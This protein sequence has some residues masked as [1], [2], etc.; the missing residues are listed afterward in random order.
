MEQN[1]LLEILAPE[2]GD[3]VFTESLASTLQAVRGR[4]RRRSAV[5]AAGG[6]VMAVTAL[7]VLQERVQDLGTPSRSRPPELAAASEVIST[8]SLPPGMIVESS[9]DSLDWIETSPAESIELLDDDE[10]LSLAPGCI[11]ITRL[12]GH[13]GVMLLCDELQRHYRPE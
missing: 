2:S 12:H 9:S 11:G 8:I 1:D 6:L 4:R 7:L 13:A 3:S 5:Q 10:L